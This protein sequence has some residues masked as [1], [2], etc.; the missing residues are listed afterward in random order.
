LAAIC[1]Y[2]VGEALKAV[3]A[4]VTLDLDPHAKLV[5]I[6]NAMV[7]AVIKNQ[8]E[9]AISAREEKNLPPE[10]FKRIAKTRR[11]FDKAVRVV[12]EEGCAS[13]QFVLSDPHLTTL[14]IGGISTWIQ[15][16]YRPEGRLTPSEIA[17]GLTELIMRMVGA[18]R[19][20]ST[21]PFEYRR[22]KN[23]SV[24]TDSVKT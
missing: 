2:G 21:A 20:I 23:G 16:W 22:R 11:A 24:I 13:G 9:N 10:Y 6:C 12:L 8:K 7:A 3:H 18:D 14:A 15:V 19:P 5:K 1:E 4:I 17:D